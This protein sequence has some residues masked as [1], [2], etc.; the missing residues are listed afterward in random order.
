MANARGTN[1][2]RS[3]TPSATNPGP[4][5]AQKKPATRANS[6]KEYVYMNKK[7]LY[8]CGQEKGAW[9]TA[10]AHD[11]CEGL[12]QKGAFITDYEEGVTPSVQQIAMTVLR[13][14]ADLQSR[15]VNM[16]WCCRAVARLLDEVARDAAEAID[17]KMNR[18]LE[19]LEEAEGGVA[20]GDAAKWGRRGGKE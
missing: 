1:L 7:Q 5:Q 17:R 3:G 11:A 19:I 18:V 13:M 4:S 9:E 2:S 14:G 15:D 8:E 12:H 20:G 6:P 10:T 16:A